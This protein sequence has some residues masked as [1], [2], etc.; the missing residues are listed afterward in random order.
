MNK[1]LFV[2]GSFFPEPSANAICCME[3]MKK[4]RDDGNEIHCIVN[5]W[6]NMQRFE[7]IEG[8]FV[9]R[10]SIPLNQRLQ[11]RYSTG[12]FSNRLCRYLMKV[13][14][15]CYRLISAMCFPYPTMGFA[16]A[17]LRET[18][19]I[20][21]SHEI[22]T[23]ICVN[24]PITSLFVGCKLKKKNTDVRFIAYLLDPIKNGFSHPWLSKH[25]ID[26]MLDT[27]QNKVVCEFD[28]IIAQNEH[29]VLFKDIKDE[30][31]RK[32]ICY[33]GAPLLVK[34]IQEAVPLSGPKKNVIYAGGLSSTR[35]PAYLI[36]VFR[37]VDSAVLHIYSTNQ[38]AWLKDMVSNH[39]NVILHPPIEHSRLMSIMKGAD[40]L[41]SI[42]NTQSEYAPSK[43]IECISFGKPI[44]AT[45]RTDYDT[46]KTYMKKYPHGLYVD[47]RCVAVQTAARAIEDLLEFS[48]EEIAFSELS[49]TYWGNTPEAFIE[50]IYGERGL[51]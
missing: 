50:T 33:L 39:P 26:H 43:I 11:K 12:E 32:K 25:R 2:L 41:V 30:R 34:K 7:K 36:D 49:D 15:G 20:L 1:I 37:Y 31:F 23:V 9:H 46:C 16:R 4:L 21:N 28:L 44:I 35:S 6:G 24:Q 22:D 13:L 47:E 42:G 48:K 51:R 19:S 18:K 45:Y 27:L 8:I 3:I 29:E 14:H 10:V 17:V 40:A 38:S 5:H